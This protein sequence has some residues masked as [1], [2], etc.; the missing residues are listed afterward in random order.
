MSKENK[1]KKVEANG[2]VFYAIDGI[3]DKLFQTKDGAK[4]Y[5]KKLNKK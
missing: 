4:N 1:I 5:L 2:L 3:N